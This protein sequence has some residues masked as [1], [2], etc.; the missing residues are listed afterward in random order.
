M[1]FNLHRRERKLNIRSKTRR[2]IDRES[3]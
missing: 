3:L 1:S 2:N